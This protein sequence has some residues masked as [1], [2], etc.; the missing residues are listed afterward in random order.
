V[1]DSTRQTNSAARA[2]GAVGLLGM[3]LIHL[4][5]SLDQDVRYI[6]WLYMALIAGSAVLALW[7]LARDSAAAWTG[8]LLMAALVIAAYVL[9]RTTGLPNADDDIGKWKEPLGVA[10]LFV[11][12]GIVA[13]AL[14]RFAFLR[15]PVAAAERRA[16]ERRRDE[17]RRETA[18]QGFPAPDRRRAER[19]RGVPTTA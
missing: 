1:N 15:A 18:P 4:L 12:G 8:A 11:E 17:R 5:D 7:L 19:R 10:S 16:E 9:S 6:F 13:L 3:G 2:V 14:F